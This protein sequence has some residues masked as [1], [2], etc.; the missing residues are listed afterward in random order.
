MVGVANSAYQQALTRGMTQAVAWNTTTVDW[1][2]AEKG[3]H[4]NPLCLIL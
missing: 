1:T 3:E 2:V 4:I